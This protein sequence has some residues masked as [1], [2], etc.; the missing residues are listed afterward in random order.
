MGDT[1]DDESLGLAN[2]EILFEADETALRDLDRVV[3]ALAGRIGIS[4]GVSPLLAKNAPC[5]TMH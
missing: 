4:P 2:S 1:D 5:F 3:E